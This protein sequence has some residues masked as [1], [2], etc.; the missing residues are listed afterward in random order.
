MCSAHDHIAKAGCPARGPPFGHQLLGR[1]LPRR[2]CGHGSS[3]PATHQSTHMWE[4]DRLSTVL[5]CVDHQSAAHGA[6]T[7]DWNDLKRIVR[8][9]RLKD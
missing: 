4:G 8:V 2:N 5:H 9:E 1:S 6:L 7:D 3:E